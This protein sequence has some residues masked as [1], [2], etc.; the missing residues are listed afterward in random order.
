[1]KKTARQILAD[2]TRSAIVAGSLLFLLSNEPATAQDTAASDQSKRPWTIPSGDEIREL[3]AQRMRD[4]GVGIVV[5]VIEPAGRRIVAYGRSGAA[6]G[7]P[8][9]GDTVFQIGSVTKVFT[10]LLLA[11]MVQ[12]GEGK[13]RSGASH[14]SMFKG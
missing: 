8:L 4:N 14:R 9:D 12:R 5:G 3:L 1:M 7:R 6:D 10:T 13:L 2:H 11:D